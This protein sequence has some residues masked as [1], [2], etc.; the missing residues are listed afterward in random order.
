M[1]YFIIIIC[2]HKKH[3]N[4][5]LHVSSHQE[6]RERVSTTVELPSSTRLL[7]TELP[8]PPYLPVKRYPAPWQAP[9]AQRQQGAGRFSHSGR[10]I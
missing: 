2:Q 10:R 4:V 6:V 3:N 7:A 1:I 8:F 9:L 5:F